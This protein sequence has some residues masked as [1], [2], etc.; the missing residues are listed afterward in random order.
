M[1]IGAVIFDNDG[2]LVDSEAIHVRIELEFLAELGLHY[3]F[4]TYTSRFVGL[5]DTRFLAELA[6]DHEAAGLGPFPADFAER[7]HAR[8]WDRLLEVLKPLP[9]ID[10]LL[11]ATKELPRAVAS[12]AS[13]FNLQA[14]LDR[15]GLSAAFEP[16]LYSAEIVGRGKP[17]PDL[18]LYTANALAVA[19][20]QCL[21]IED[22][23]NGVLAARA[24]GMT[25]VGYIG[26]GH[27]DPDL[28][29]RLMAAGAHRVFSDHSTIARALEAGT[30]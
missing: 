30:L 5:D 3:E 29:E 24:A 22:S 17:A 7:L 20:E 2:V 10:D 14:K 6:E 11:Q 4:S 15:V 23:R 28:G 19:P 1:T 26:G 13:S 9:G 12:S 21:V 25:A 27:A 18:F 16:H 8:G